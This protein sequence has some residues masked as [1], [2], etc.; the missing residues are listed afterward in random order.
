M[1]IEKLPNSTACVRYDTPIERQ[2]LAGACPTFTSREGWQGIISQTVFGASFWS[3]RYPH[4]VEVPES[5]LD[6]ALNAL[7]ADEL[8][9]EQLATAHPKRQAARE[10]VVIV[11][12]VYFAHMDVLE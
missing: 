10:H 9:G 5:V 12:E 7:I 4:E 11:L 2:V 3:L 6:Q 1:D 8:I